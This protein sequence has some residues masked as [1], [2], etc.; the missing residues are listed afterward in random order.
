MVGQ[1]R[2][3]QEMY[4]YIVLLLA[5]ALALEQILANR[6]YRGEREEA[7]EANS[8]LPRA[9]SERLGWKGS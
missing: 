5:A 7:G 6:F 3:G 4:P 2:V 8:W 9:W 1:Q